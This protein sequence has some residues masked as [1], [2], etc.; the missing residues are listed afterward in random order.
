TLVRVLVAGFAAVMSLVAA[1]AIATIYNAR[2][3]ASGAAAV[4]AHQLVATRALDEVERE[5]KV[6]NA[7][8]YRLSRTPETVDRESVLADLDQT[9]RTISELVQRAAGSPEE[10]I[11]RNLERASRDFSSEARRLL[12]GKRV[13]TNT[14]RDLFFR[15]EEVTTEVAQLV[16]LSYQRAL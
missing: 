5:Q 8:M 11:W 12:A 16:D 3:L 7:A 9:D 10:P 14:S 1:A 13:T 4:A 15:H 6:L 2:S